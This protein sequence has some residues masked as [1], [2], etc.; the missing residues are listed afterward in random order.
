MK[1]LLG[2]M[3]LG[4]FLSACASNDKIV[5][6]GKLKQNLTKSELQD[7]LFNSY[8]G[9]D[10]FIPGGGSLFINENN[11]EI[12]WG[13]NKNTYYVFRFVSE[14]VSCGMVLCKLGNGGLES[15]HSSLKAAKASLPKKELNQTE[16]TSNTSITNSSTSSSST[17]TSTSSSGSYNSTK[18]AICYGEMTRA[19]K[20]RGFHKRNRVASIKVKETVCK[21][22][23]KGEINN[24]EGKGL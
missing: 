9:D 23:A 6:S 16:Q 14:T 11:A 3:V 1:K 13:S 22:Y 7:V 21:A 5:N 8:P 10:P 20:K 24:Y 4:L 12:I 19:H 18:Y 17:S 15:W 2:I